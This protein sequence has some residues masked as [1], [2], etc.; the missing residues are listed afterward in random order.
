[1]Q[2]NGAF[3]TT[4]NSP[5]YSKKFSTFAEALEFINERDGIYYAMKKRWNKT[6]GFYRQTYKETSCLPTVK[7]R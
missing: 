6:F 7:K 5:Y 2:D 1:M 4:L 3:D